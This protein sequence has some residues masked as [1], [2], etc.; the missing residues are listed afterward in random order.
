MEHDIIFSI[1]LIFSGA[2]VLSTFALMT[3]QSMLVAYMLLGILFGPWGLK[4]ISNIDMLRTVSDVGIIFLLFLLGLN[5]P[6]QKLIITFKKITWIAVISSLIFL[7]VG[8]FVTYYFGYLT[9]E[10]LVIGGAMMFSSTIIGIKLL[11]TTILHHQHIGEVMISVLLLQDLIAIAVLFLLHGASQAGKVLIDIGLVALGFPAILVFSYL[12][13]RFVLFLLF[14]KFSR[15]KEYLFLLAIGWCL[16]MAQ[17]ASLLGLSGEVGAFI[18]GIS[19]AP[20]PVSVY[21]SESL[22]P[23]RDF[24]LVLFFFSVGATFDLNFLSVV[25]V[26]ALILLA[27]LIGIKPFTYQILLRCIGES[28]QIAWEIGVRLGQISEFSLIIAYMALSSHIISDR[29]A[30]LIESTT[31]LSFIVSSYWVVIKYPTPLAISDRLRRD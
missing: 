25:I 23:I 3:H 21:I 17:L 8:Y 6:P 12:F 9:M 27:L 24:F 10:C 26:P 1:F 2:A 16:S 19:L 13:S 18:A 14:S 11:P 31:I 22:K 30:Y 20:K 29:A 4:L 15:I 7:I 5:L 28:K